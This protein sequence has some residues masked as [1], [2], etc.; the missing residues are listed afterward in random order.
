M[1]FSLEMSNLTF[2][3]SGVG[4]KYRRLNHEEIRIKIRFLLVG[5][6]CKLFPD[7]L[8]ACQVC[9]NNPQRLNK[10]LN[11]QFEVDVKIMCKSLL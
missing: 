7:C 3:E 8:Q 9:F 2:K 10:I 5:L 4:L 1:L 11:F 6:C